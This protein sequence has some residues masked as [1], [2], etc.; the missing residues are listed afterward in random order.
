MSNNRER[1]HN[2]LKN[3]GFIENASYTWRYETVTRGGHDLHCA[4]FTF[5]KMVV[6]N[7]DLKADRAS[8]KEEAATLALQ[9]SETVTLTDNTQASERLEN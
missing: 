6:Q 2:V 7:R 4:I 9:P 8:A 5:G 3:A 1:L